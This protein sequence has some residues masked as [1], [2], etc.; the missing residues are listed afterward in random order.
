[1]LKK[2]KKGAGGAGRPSR[3]LRSCLS[4]QSQGCR[5]EVLV[6]SRWGWAQTTWGFL[7]QHRENCR[8]SPLLWCFVCP[9]PSGLITALLL[10]KHS[11]ADGHSE[12]LARP[13]A[14]DREGSAGV[15]T[16][17]VLQSE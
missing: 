16:A 8:P 11:P 4:G 10:R 6:M 14:R 2:K 9:P 13:T 3:V 17:S 12:H 1:M 15:V 5:S 7:I